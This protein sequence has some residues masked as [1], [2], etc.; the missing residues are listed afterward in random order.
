[1]HIVILNFS[2]LPLPLISCFLQPNPLL[3]ELQLSRVFYQFA[4]LTHELRLPL[5]QLLPITLLD[6]PLT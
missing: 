4:L 3:R 6:F 5:Q 2:T 1:M